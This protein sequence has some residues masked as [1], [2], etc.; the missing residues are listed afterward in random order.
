MLCAAVFGDA[1]PTVKGV[2]GIRFSRTK[3]AVAVQKVPREGIEVVRDV[4]YGASAH[5]AQ[6]SVGAI[7]RVVGH[8]PVLEGSPLHCLKMSALTT[9]GHIFYL[10]VIL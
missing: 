1:C 3:I 4:L 5:A 10:S 6:S 8:V 9:F 7:I 2:V